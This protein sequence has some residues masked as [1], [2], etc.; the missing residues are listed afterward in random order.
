MLD[1]Q[2]FVKADSRIIFIKVL[3][4]H[5]NIGDPLASIREAVSWSQNPHMFSQLFI[6]ET[7]KKGIIKTVSFM[8][9]KV[10]ISQLG[11]FEINSSIVDDGYRLPL[12]SSA[13]PY[14]CIVMPSKRLEL[15]VLSYSKSDRMNLST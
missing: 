4:D 2:R 8:D 15:S 14:F 11:A 6:N 5:C 13:G 1:N 12:K 7:M 10:F 3:N 9:H